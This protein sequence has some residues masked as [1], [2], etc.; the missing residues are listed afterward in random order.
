MNERDR[1]LEAFQQG[2]ED[3]QRRRWPASRGGLSEAEQA[4]YNRGWEAGGEESVYCAPH[5][6]RV[7]AAAQE[8]GP[9]AY[10]RNLP[11]MAPAAPPAGGPGDTSATGPKPH[12]R[13]DRRRPAWAQNPE[14]SLNL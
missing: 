4:A 10:R 9:G 7:A 12:S 13:S 2:Y 14:R 11:S 1:A 6:P 8:G 5:D 3:R